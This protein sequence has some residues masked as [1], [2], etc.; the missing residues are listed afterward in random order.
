MAGVGLAVAASQG[1]A[2]TDQYVQNLTGRIDELRPIVEEFD[3]K[4][5]EYNYTRESAIAECNNAIGLLDAL[6]STYVS[7]VERYEMLLAHQAELMGASVWMRPL[8][9]ARTYKKDIA[10]SVYSV[11]KPAVPATEVG[12]A[13]GGG[14]FLVGY[15]ILSMLF[16]LLGSLAGG[17][18]GYAH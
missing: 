17:G 6:C 11:Y 13:Y 12:F 10:E 16:G 2:F 7:T 4:I 14:G 9:L 1:P 15:L 8:T 5:A 3:A 18:R